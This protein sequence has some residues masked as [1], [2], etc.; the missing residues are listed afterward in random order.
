[1]L[2]SLIQPVN[3]TQ[4]LIVVDEQE[5]IARETDEAPLCNENQNDATS[6][7]N[8]SVIP[9]SVSSRSTQTE[10]TDTSWYTTCSTV[11]KL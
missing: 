9:S 1:M 6:S 11:G 3:A 4:Q 8:L 10:E 5:V 7:G 2:Y